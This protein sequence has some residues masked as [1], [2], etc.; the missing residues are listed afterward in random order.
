MEI[1]IVTISRAWKIAYEKGLEPKPAS[2]FETDG[3]AHMHC[4]KLLTEYGHQ[5]TS[6]NMK[7]RKSSRSSAFPQKR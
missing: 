7:I 1:H 5:A 6:E 3:D 2:R 4:V